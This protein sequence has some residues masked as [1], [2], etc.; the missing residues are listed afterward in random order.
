MPL[1]GTEI[2][3]FAAIDRTEMT[4]FVEL[5]S[6]DRCA[7]DSGGSSDRCAGDNGNRE[8]AA[9]AVCKYNLRRYQ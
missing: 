1:T 7:E 3:T 4:A 2:P 5:L 8:L 9:F 6:S